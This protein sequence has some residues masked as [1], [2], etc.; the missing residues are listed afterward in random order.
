MSNQNS[1]K[2]IRFA[3]SGGFLVFAAGAY[4][5]AGRRAFFAAA[6]AVL[7]HEAGHLLA[8][9]PTGGRPTGIRM[10]AFGM[11]IDFDGRGSALAAAAGPAAGLLLAAL[12]RGDTGRA[13]LA[14]SLFNL[15]PYS[16]L[17]GGRM[18]RGRITKR[19]ETL[20]DGAVVLF[21]LAAGL[22]GRG[23][24]AGGFWLLIDFAFGLL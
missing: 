1:Y 6:A 22:F 4:V 24:A 3:V 2:N 14:L 20:L 10:E 21:M 5:L 19:T 18:L 12:A 23:A 17:D 13:S 9:L 11:C 8:M 16:K 15:L 7:A